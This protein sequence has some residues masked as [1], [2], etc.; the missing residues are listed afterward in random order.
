MY[1]FAVFTYMYVYLYVY[2]Y[3]CMY[4][5]S[6]FLY[7][8]IMYSGCPMPPLQFAAYLE[9]SGNICMCIYVCT[10]FILIILIDSSFIKHP[11]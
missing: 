4:M 11:P 7:N 6:L 8:Y 3:L 10:R 5:C 9:N 2:L 1:L